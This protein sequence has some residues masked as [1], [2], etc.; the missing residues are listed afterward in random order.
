MPISP[1]RFKLYFDK[2]IYIILDYYYLYN[3]YELILKKVGDIDLNNLT[4][5]LNDK[6]SKIVKVGYKNLIKNKEKE[7]EKEEEEK[8][9]KKSFNINVDIFLNAPIFLL[10]L[11]FKEE[12]NT[13][14][15]SISFGQLKINSKLADDKNKDDIYDKY[16][17]EFSNIYV[18]TLKKFSNQ[19]NIKA[20]DGEKILFPSSFYVDIQNYI[21]TKPLIELKN[22]NFSPILVNANLNNTAFSLSEEQI[23]FMIRYLENFQ[24]TQFE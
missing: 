6:I 13:E 15:L 17:I 5:M 2:Q 16:S 24:R 18:K 22:D 3:I 10:P 12:N 21:Y 11:Y 4:S 8:K 7:K 19:E 20:E 14:L 9:I 23:I 1:F